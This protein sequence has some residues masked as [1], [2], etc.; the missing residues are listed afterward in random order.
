LYL[1][2]GDDAMTRR[3]IIY[4]AALHRRWRRTASMGGPQGELR[5]AESLAAGLRRIGLRVTEIGSLRGFAL[6][7][8]TPR[9]GAAGTLYFF[10][11]WTLELA[12]RYRLI[13]KDDVCRLRILE[14]FGTPPARVTTSLPR[15]QPSQYLLPHPD[16][17][18]NTFLGYL[19]QNE[20][21]APLADDRALG[22]QIRRG[23]AAGL[24]R[25]LI[26]GKEARYLDGPASSVV[27]RVAT[28]CELRA[29]IARA[30]GYREGMLP[31][32]VI[33]HGALTAP[34]WRALLRESSFVLG[35]GDPVLGPTALEG[36]AE[37]CVYLNPE[38]PQPR[39][40]NGIAELTIGS[41]HPYAAR[42]GPPFVC[43]FN[44]AQPGSAE[45]AARASLDD[46]NRRARLDA[47]DTASP[48]MAALTPFTLDA[49]LD[50]LRRIVALDGVPPPWQ[51]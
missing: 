25:G 41:Q 47:V 17:G 2:H 27:A 33:N 9:R 1:S 5:M 28:V 42:I 30:R 48:L 32:G 34:A 23:I 15:V 14:W 22:A 46:R 4:T 45:H 20:A 35:L 43:G 10:D 39:R 24:R 50:R 29:T 3:A 8:L 21:G 7:R 16:N 44:P 40:V 51:P 36:L 49:Y 13:G 18:P 19:L 31:S 12:C 11:P 26:W 6:H 38:Y 37:G